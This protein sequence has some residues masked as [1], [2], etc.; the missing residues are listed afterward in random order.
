MNQIDYLIVGQGLA[1][2]ALAAQL[3]L[4]NKSIMVM[5]KPAL[6]T[7]S[8][9]APGLFNPLTGRKMVKTWMAEEVF[10]YLDTFYKHIEEVTSQRFFYQKPIYRPF[11]SIEEQNEWAAASIDPSVSAFVQQVFTTSAY[12]HSINDPFGGLLLQQSGY[13]NTKEY[14]A[15]VRC[16]LTE[17]GAFAE[18]V[19]DENALVIGEENVQ[20]KQYTASRI[21]FCEGADVKKSR[22]FGWLPIKPLKGETLEI[23]A[24]LPQGTIFNR[25]VYVVPGRDSGSWRAG[26]TYEHGTIDAGISEKG[27]QELESKLIQLITVPYTV[28]SQQAGIRPTTPNRRPV[29]GCH[30]EYKNVAVFNGFGT[31]GVSLAP[32]FSEVLIRSL[33]NNEGIN[34][35]VDI[36]RYN[37]LYCKSP[38]NLWV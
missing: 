26:A 35:E 9:V 23:T 19:L 32:Y 28:T 20:Y 3:L 30:P 14:I 1:G 25:G 17:K 38:N 15:A 29:I 10:G 34:K 11:L 12:P 4:R 22:L 36:S 2:S 31:K 16:W 5:D 7:S 6:N 24:A 33:E 18:E 37:S 8:T 13:L 27:R 21:I